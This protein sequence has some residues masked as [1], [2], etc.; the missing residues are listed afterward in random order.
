[1][2]SLTKALISLGVDDFVI[3]AEG[4]PS[5]EAELDAGLI[6]FAPDGTEQEGMTYIA[7]VTWAQISTKVAELEAA[8]PLNQFRKERDR[9]IAE[10]DWWVLPDRMATQA[11]LDYR[12]ELRDITDTYTSLADVTWPTK[13]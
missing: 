9:L 5:T 8:E 13:P 10:T 4:T 3:N 2:K 12:Q 11:Q 1:M 6:T 7:P